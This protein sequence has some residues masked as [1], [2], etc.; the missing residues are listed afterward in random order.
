MVKKSIVLFG[1]T[2]DPIHVGHTTVATSAADHIGADEVVF[3]PAKRSPLKHLR[4]QVSDEHRLKM[5]AIAVGDDKRFRVS[6][7]E[8]NKPEPS[9]TLETVKWFKEQYGANVSLYWLL[10][11]DAVDDFGLWYKVTELIDACNMCTMFRAGC[12]EPD[13]GKYA[14]KWGKSRV[15]KLRANVIATPLVDVS[16]TEIRGRLAGGQEVAGMLA[17]GVAEYICE[18]GLY[19]PA[20]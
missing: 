2:F 15:E 6:D 5:I 17:P 9:F 8:I 14:G 3:V 4:P 20:S 10:G 11:A 18:H 16:S 12:D 1:G 19:R 13:F 7:H